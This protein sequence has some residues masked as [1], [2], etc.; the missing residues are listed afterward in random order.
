MEGRFR[1]YQQLSLSPL[2]DAQ[3]QEALEQRLGKERAEKLLPYVRDR[4]PLDTMTKA[5]VTSNPLM[6]SMVASVFELSQGVAM[7]NSV[8]DL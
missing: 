8:S 4:V 7:P 2:S 3:Q 5:K 1:A 6:L